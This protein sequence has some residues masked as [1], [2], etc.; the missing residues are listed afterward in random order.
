M[1]IFCCGMRRSGSTLQYQIATD[2][3]TRRG[4]GEGL[5]Y[6][7]PEEF[8]RQIEAHKS[9]HR[10]KVVKTHAFI[11]GAGR[12]LQSG[13]AKA[14]YSYRDI[15]D[16]VVSLMQMQKVPFAKLRDEGMIYALLKEHADWSRAGKALVS[17]YE[18]LTADVA[19]EVARI[20]AYLGIELRDG[21]AAAV[22]AEYAL[23]RQKE[24]ISHLDPQQLR[25]NPDGS[26]YDAAMLLHSNHI[27]SGTQGRWQNVLSRREVALVEHIARDWMREQG[28]PF[29]QPWLSRKAAGIRFHLRQ[30]V[31]S[32]LGLVGNLSV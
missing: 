1:W 8:D 29:S 30:R 11:A 18:Q 6:V 2:L 23:E 27:N 3:V 14:L 12:L 7:V 4:V 20:A 31:A 16:V 25:E 24:R 5:G 10:L 17:R 22:A 32:K 19:G 13:Q 9:D 15:R 26:R 21:E 28:Y